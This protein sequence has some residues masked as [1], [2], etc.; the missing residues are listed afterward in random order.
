MLYYLFEYLSRHYDF[1]GLRLFQY[2]TFRTS[3]AVIISLII[4]T[5]YGRR[6][7][8]YLQKMQVGETVRNLGL[9]GQ[10]QKQGTPTMGGI[11][12]LLG[13][14]VPT[15]LLA[16]LTNVYVILMIITTIWM[17]AVG[18]LDDYIKV[19]KKN[20]EGLAGRFKI[21]GQVGLGLII[22]CTMYYNPNIVVRQTVDEAGIS[23]V[24]T[25]PM[26][27]RQKGESFYYTQ[28]V[29][30]TLTNVPFYK[31]N[32]FDYAKVLKF[33][34][35]GYE[36]YAALVFIIITVIIITA[37]SNGANIT[38]GIDGLATG[39]SAII[40]ITLGLLAYVSGNTV[41]ADYLN[42]MYIP[43]SGELM[44]FAGA[45]VG[46][47][48]GFLWYNS[49]PAQVFMGDTGSLAIGGIIAAFA[50]MIRKELLIPVL[51]G[52][53]LIEILSVMIQ[54]SYFKYTKKRFGEGRRIFLMS[55]LHHHYQKK[56]Y[57]EAK[58]VTRFWIISILLAIITI[59]TLKL[60]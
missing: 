3:L 57:H 45:F 6:L 53:F 7:I 29:K 27:L 26:V 17:G 43:N 55:P 23:K 41:I 28:D 24:A 13:I 44:I 46:A 8:N 37:V 52:V 56:G 25:A 18:F 51:C 42:I 22:G 33:L 50:I 11:M 32:E 54:V 38:D 12:I 60:R 19:F 1:P 10:M 4:T 47:C 21:V 31:N 36:K 49:Y 9:E 30:S 15:L 16:N 34:G 35:D 48:V 20:K 14:L 5:V 40:G 58:I 59:I 2:I 39:T